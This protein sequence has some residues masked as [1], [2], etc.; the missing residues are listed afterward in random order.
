MTGTGRQPETRPEDIVHLLAIVQ[1]DPTAAL[2]EMREEFRR[3]IVATSRKQGIRRVPSQETAGV[4]PAARGVRRYDHIAAR[5][6]H[7]PEQICP[8][9]LAD[10]E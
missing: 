6:R 1:S 4:G 8:G 10:A 7:E 2:E 9:C 3:P 5:R